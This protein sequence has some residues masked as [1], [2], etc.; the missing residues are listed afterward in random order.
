M[1]DH[2]QPILKPTQSQFPKVSW[3]KKAARIKWKRISNTVATEKKSFPRYATDWRNVSVFKR[4]HSVREMRQRESRSWGAR[5]L[6]EWLK[7]ANDALAS[8]SA[9]WRSHEDEG[10]GKVG[11]RMKL[12][13]WTPPPFLILALL[14][15]SVCRW[16]G[17]GGEQRQSVRKTAVLVFSS[18]DCS[19][20]RGGRGWEGNGLEPAEDTR[21]SCPRISHA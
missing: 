16:I 11:G 18:V 19:S 20:A 14:S 21:S 2:S 6:H 15:H 1:N 4:V 5:A 3:T 17:S 7:D 10:M 9:Q 13:K 8:A 12:C